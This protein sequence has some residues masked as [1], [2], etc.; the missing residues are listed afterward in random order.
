VAVPGVTVVATQGEKKLSTSTNEQGLY[1]F[2]DLADGPWTIHVELFGFAPL[3]K[4][5]TI[6]AEP[7]QLTFELA[8][9]PFDD[10]AKNLPRLAP[11]A[12]AAATASNG[13]AP[14][15][16]RA[17]ATNSGGF[18]RADVTAAAR[19]AASA[20]SAPA[21][22][23]AEPPPA[24]EQAS[25]AA[26]GM[27][28]NGSV[29][30][31][32]ASPFAQPAA[33]GNNRRTGRSLYSYAAGINI[34]T[35]KWDSPQY[36]FGGVQSKQS[37]NDTHFLGSVQG[38]L[39]IPGMLQR[40]PVVYLGYQHTEDHNANSQS[41]IVPTALERAGDFSQS[42][43]ALGQPITLINPQT[44]VPFDNNRISPSQ[45]SPQAAALLR[46][47][48]LPNLDPGGRF[49]FE[50]PTLQATRQDSVQMRVQQ[51]INQ[52]N[53]LQGILS[54][55]RT[56][57]DSTSLFGFEDES[58]NSVVDANVT[59]SRRFNQFF[60][61]RPRGQYTQQ[62]N[63]TTP[64]F[65]DRVNV[66]GDAGITGN[67]QIPTNWGPPALV[68]SSG[69]LG[70]S[71]ALPAFTRTRSATGGSEAFWYK[72]R[73]NITMGGDVRHIQTDV[74]SQQDPRGR[75]SFDGAVSGSD[76]GD[77]LLG[78]PRTTS[79]A[80]GNAD[81]YY[82][83]MQYDA[84]FNDDLRLS[85]SFTVM[86]GARWEYEGP[87]TE[88]QGRLV[89]LD[90]AQ[91]FTQ[92]APVVANSPT[93]PITGTQYVSSLIKPDKFGVQPRLALAWRPVPGSSLVV[94]AAYGVYRNTNVYQPIATLLGQQPPLSRTFSVENSATNPLTLAN[95][96]VSAAPTNATNTFAVDPE[97]RVGYAQ[98]WNA[99]VQRD[100]PASL[101][102]TASYLG[103]H[104]SHLLQ[105]FLP[106]S[107]PLGT[108]NPC[109]ACPAGFVYLTSGGHSDR[110]AGQLQIRRR[111][112]N[113]FTWTTN[114]TLAKAT[115]NA[116]AFNGPSLGGNAVAQNWL[117]LDAELG[118]SSFDQRHNF[119]AQVQ[120]TTGVGVA[121][122]GLLTGVKGALVK[123]WTVTA[124]L[125]AGSGLPVTPVVLT[126]IPG[127]GVL[128]A[129][130]ADLTGISTK[131][132][133]EGAYL[134]PAAY[135][136]PFG[137]FGNVGRNSERG[138]KQ[139]GLNMNITRTF[140]LSQRFNMDWSA[141][142]TNL[143]N[144]VTFSRINTSVGSSQFGLPVDANTMRKI[145]T[146]V[147][148]RF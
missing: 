139:F 141:N 79:I 91:G 111:L 16:A 4:D 55:Q 83:S 14:A 57:N 85:P 59:W 142:V 21:A 44:G 133:P 112:R 41:T 53:S 12:P 30:N 1:R 45:L 127:T 6:T 106:N 3:S 27:L 2:A 87:I 75:F 17:N 140:V 107:Y 145:Q 77:F 84:Y 7:Q 103:T 78:I 49:N 40:R 119:T 25:A 89:N 70:L 50:G 134:N 23:A 115:D 124:N 136:A 46:L 121:G 135:V 18:Q 24:P 100:F 68:F 110:H 114:Y 42:V 120:Y 146:M 33:F 35:S 8:L 38:P 128:G 81:K 95:A 92:V 97:L 144:R 80:N 11:A 36:S 32:A 105:Q 126:Q 88:Q 99:S 67:N 47:Y 64:F 118:P 131:D 96:F 56:A 22:P 39:K 69:V 15:T 143:L 138:P 137:H 101:T 43:N 61:I 113:G 93:G 60:T 58:R 86:L 102:I 34:G 65:A 29:N 28:I 122:G 129:L 104:G 132:V 125:N 13:A 48:P 19:P 148:L 31:G 54:Y 62:T 26:D 10:I 72:G 76:L 37:Y 130:R 20:N 117:D 108:V 73:H 116:T 94:R 9:L 52:R 51:T 71:D 66:S 63:R 90:V 147:R 98:N 123:N 109:P 82:R 5:V 74:L